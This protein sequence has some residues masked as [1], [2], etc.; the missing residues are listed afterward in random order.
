MLE[1][2]K[3]KTSEE[4]PIGSQYEWSKSNFMNITISWLI[5][6]IVVGS[7]NANNW[8][9]NGCSRNDNSQWTWKIIEFQT[10]NQWYSYE[11]EFFSDNKYPWVWTKLLEEML[12]NIKG[13]TDTVMIPSVLSAIRFYQKILEKFKQE[14]II[15]GYT[16]EDNIFTVSLQ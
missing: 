11:W 12:N 1:N 10:D 13:R 14:W 9:L 4:N 15:K 16:Q 5:E 3:I 2:L 6:G 7:I 8:T